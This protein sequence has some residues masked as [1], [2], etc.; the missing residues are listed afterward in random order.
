MTELGLTH[1][2][3]LSAFLFACGLLCSLGAKSLGSPPRHEGTKRTVGSRGGEPGGRA[4]MSLRA[5]TLPAPFV[6]VGDAGER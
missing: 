6:V 5:L 1:F 3:V 4:S 2:M